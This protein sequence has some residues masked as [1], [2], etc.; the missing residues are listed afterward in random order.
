MWREV[1]GCFDP[2]ARP[3]HGNQ[4]VGC[5]LGGEPIH[6]EHEIVRTVIVDI[7]FEER[8]H[9]I[10]PHVV[11]STAAGERLVGRQTEQTRDSFCAALGAPDQ[12]DVEPA[13]GL[14]GD[15]GD[16]STGQQEQLIAVLD[17]HTVV[18]EQSFAPPGIPGSGSVF[19]RNSTTEEAEEFFATKAVSDAEVIDR[20]S[21]F[22]TPT[23]VEAVRRQQQDETDRLRLTALRIDRVREAQAASAAASGN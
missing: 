1:A 10:P 5:A 11:H 17:E 23:Q 6:V 19:N 13:G 9:V 2:A 21:G 22:L 14:A 3:E 20:V 4:Q 16:L 7:R 15:G 18:D 12:P 8:P